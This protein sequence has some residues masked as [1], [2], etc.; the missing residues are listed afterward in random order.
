MPLDVEFRKLWHDLGMHG[1]PTEVYSW[2]KNQY[3][4]TDRHYHNLNHIEYGLRAIDKLAEPLLLDNEKQV[5]DRVRFAF[6]F[7]DCLPDE[8]RSADIARFVCWLGKK[9]EYGYSI[10]GFI[11][12]T[13]HRGFPV[14]VSQHVMVD[15]DLAIFAASREKFDEYELLVRQEYSHVPE[16]KYRA[17]RLKILTSFL[18][19]E[20]I[21]YTTYGQREW[22]DLASEN[23]K[24]SIGKL[25]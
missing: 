4:G 23:L 18:D 19:R 25:V 10:E 20:R 16:D 1:E 3:N 21:Y 8:S 6:W 2:L 24:R 14:Y 17:G 7:H 5:F 12:L 22:E 9:P 15:A 13:T 11:A